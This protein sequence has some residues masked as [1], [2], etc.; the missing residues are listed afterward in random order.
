MINK[1]LFGIALFVMLIGSMLLIKYS[2]EFFK[3]VKERD[4]YYLFKIGKFSV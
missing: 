3:L 1:I 2:I 4:G